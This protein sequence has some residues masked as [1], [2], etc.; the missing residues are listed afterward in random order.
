NV[1]D[2]IR[3][4]NY[5]NVNNKVGQIQLSDKTLLNDTSINKV[6][7]DMTA[8]ATKNKI[9]LTN[10]NDVKNNANLMQLVSNAWRA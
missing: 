3:V 6:I 2:M 1:N 10:I 8:Y 5:S 9:A 7:Q 4:Q